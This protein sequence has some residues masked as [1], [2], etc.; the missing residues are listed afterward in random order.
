[1]A[2]CDFQGLTETD[3]DSSVVNREYKL[4]SGDV[5]VFSDWDD[6]C[7]NSKKLNYMRFP[8]ISPLVDLY[9]DNSLGF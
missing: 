6:C 1:M 9:A 7:A 2:V 8:G 3:K 5:M 4:G